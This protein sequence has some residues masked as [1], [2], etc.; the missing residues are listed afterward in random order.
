MAVCATTRN[1]DLEPPCAAVALMASCDGMHCQLSG[2]SACLAAHSSGV[3]QARDVHPCGTVVSAR[4][5]Y[6]VAPHHTCAHAP[7]AVSSEHTEPPAPAVSHVRAPA[8][9]PQQPYP[10]P[11]AQRVS[12]APDV[13]R[14]A[15]GAPG[16][17]LCGDSAALCCAAWPAQCILDSLTSCV[18]AFCKGGV[19]R[20][21]DAMSHA[22]EAVD[23]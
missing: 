21:H 11:H 23:R 10:P 2:A 20:L 4:W 13:R 6:A 12:A 9:A 3:H 17:A 1:D 14:Q 18:A 8:D 15:A 16:L 22:T 5:S 19:R 7:A